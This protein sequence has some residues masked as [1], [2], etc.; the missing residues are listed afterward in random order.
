MLVWLVGSSIRF[1]F[2]DRQKLDQLRERGQPVIFCFWHNQIFCQTYLF[3]FQQIVV[4][5]SRH[6]DGEY[7]GRII[8]WFG[9]ATARGSSTRGAAR[10]LLELRRHLWEGRDVAFTIDGPR[11]PVYKVKP[12]PVFL[13]RKTGAPIVTLQSEPQGFWQLKSWDRFR[14]PKPFTRTLV[15][16]GEPIWVSAD[17]SD[18]EALQAFQCE[19]DRIRAF[20]EEQRRAPSTGAS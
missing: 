11:G 17:D 4:M 12:G 5:T 20:C 15:K 8:N 10:A 18:A 13:A 19:M 16:F 6:F 9:Y 7:V 3:R 1:R 14:I 2:E